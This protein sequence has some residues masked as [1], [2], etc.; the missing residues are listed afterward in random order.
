MIAPRD[1]GY[2]NGTLVAD[3]DTGR[4]GVL[5]VGGGFSLTVKTRSETWTPA[6]HDRLRLANNE[7]RRKLGLSPLMCP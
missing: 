5:H 4:V 7:E 3:M 6:S 2:R 1:I